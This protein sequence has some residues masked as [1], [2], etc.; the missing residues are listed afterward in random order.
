MEEILLP[1]SG[2]VREQ[3]FEFV[4][5]QASDRVKL[6]V[7]NDCVVGELA[8]NSVCAV[9]ESPAALPPWPISA[10]N[11]SGGPRRSDS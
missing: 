10:R 9:V 4:T 1:V 3:L 7:A 8:F 11:A 2:N 6:T 5:K